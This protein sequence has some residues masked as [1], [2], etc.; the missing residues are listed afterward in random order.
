MAILLVGFLA[1]CGSGPG[2]SEEEGDKVEV[3]ATIGMIADVAREVGGDRVNVVGLVGEGVDPHLYRPTVV[4][5]K[6][7]GK[8][9][10]ILFNG[11]MLEGKMADSFETMASRGKA[12]YAVA[13][14]LR[15][16]GGE[17]LSDE[18]DHDDPHVWM[19]VVR[20]KVIVGVV[21]EAL[22]AVDPAGAES[23]KG[24]AEAYQERL[25]G[26][27]EYARATIESIPEDRRVLVTAH[28]AFG[29]AELAYGITVKGVQGLSTESEAGVRDV[30]E[31]VDFLVEKKIPAVFVESSVSDKNV[32]ALLEGC[33][34][35]GHTVVIGG[36]LFSD[37]MGAEGTYEGTYVGMIDHNVTVMARAL[38]GE[39]PEKGWQGKLSEG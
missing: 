33:R 26:L 2:D 19:D 18:E 8:A 22:T 23:Y 28:D 6:L 9:D 17:I 37:A 25:G 30:E 27:D 10:V 13:E 11:L 15:E 1:G 34:A 39:A 7:M 5:V 35:Q 36:E 3:V 29:Y 21:A 32:K 38:G 12:V 31:L 16:E 24:R 4:D 20:W 14:R